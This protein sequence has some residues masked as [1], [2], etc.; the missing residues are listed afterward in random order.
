MTQSQFP[1][2]AAGHVKI[3]ELSSDDTFSIEYTGLNKADRDLLIGFFSEMKGRFGAFRFEFEKYIFPHCRFDSD[4]GPW[5]EGGPGPY[6]L[7]FPIK[8]LRPPV[9]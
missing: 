8:V 6:S 1:I 2:P 9:V 7:T 4:T 3:T 5:I